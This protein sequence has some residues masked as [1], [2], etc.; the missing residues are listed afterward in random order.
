MR[1]RRSKPWWTMTSSSNKALEHSAQNRPSA[2]LG[3]PASEGVARGRL[4]F[5]ATETEVSDDRI[6]GDARAE[7][8]RLEEALSAAADKLA[9][10]L[11]DLGDDQEAAGMIEFQLAM[12]EDDE[13]TGPVRDRITAGASALRAWNDVLRAEIEDY[14]AAADEYF[15]GRVV[16]LEDIRER[17]VRHLTG[18]MEQTIPTDCVVVAEDITPS[19]FLSTTWGCGGV[20]LT[21]GSRSS[22]VALLARSRQIPM[23]VGLE[24]MPRPVDNEV[25]LDA[26]NGALILNA[27][28]SERLDLLRRMDSIAQRRR[29]ADAWLDREIVLANGE[30]IRVLVNIAEPGELD[31]INPAHC[32]GIGLVRTEFLFHG[33]DVLPDEETQFVEYRRIVTWAD[34]KPVTFRTL[35]AGGDKPVAGLTE[36]DERNPFLGVRGIRI[37]LNHP[38]VFRVQLRALLRVSALGPVK[39]MLPMVTVAEEVDAARRLLRAERKALSDLGVAAGDP[40]FGIMVE[41]PSAAIAIESFDTDFYSIGSNDLIQYVTA[42]SRES[43]GLEHLARGDNPAVLDLIAKV[44]SHGRS[45]GREVSLCGEMAGETRYIGLLVALGLRTFSVSPGGL[46]NTKYTLARLE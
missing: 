14:E 21:R 2:L 8:T 16:D 15:R 38:D 33:R 27:A 7:T 18:R 4:R 45:G 20:A 28:G 5:L 39:I 10:M 41:V 23:V 22:H 35:D 26:D 31:N 12:I 29:E 32:D 42:C 46:A 13:L 37:S 25:F 24:A 43:S 44:V 34:G 19:T 40:E 3:T 6:G 30:S 11:E 1:C 9:T 17:V 36:A